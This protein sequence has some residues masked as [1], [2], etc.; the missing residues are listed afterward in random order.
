MEIVVAPYYMLKFCN[1]KKNEIRLT[2]V[3]GY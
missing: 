3:G 1:Y 2:N